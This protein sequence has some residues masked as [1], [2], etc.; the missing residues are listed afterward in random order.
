M[1]RITIFDLFSDA[2]AELNIKVERLRQRDELETASAGLIIGDLMT[3]IFTIRDCAAVI[4]PEF[5]YE[6]EH[7]VITSIKASTDSTVC[8]KIWN[9]DVKAF[10]N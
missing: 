4:G 3:R 1:S 10:C 8:C 7:G 6:I 2:C 9:P 5:T